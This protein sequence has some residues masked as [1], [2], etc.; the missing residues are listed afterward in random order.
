LIRLAAT[1]VSIR[2]ALPADLR[3]IGRLGALLVRTHHDF[4]PQRFIAAT[5]QTEHAYGS[6]LGTQL[7]EPNI[8][9]IV[10]DRSGEAI[11]Y[12]YA[13]IEG[14]DYMSLRGPAGVLY[15]IVFDPQLRRQGIGRMLLDATLAELK[16]RGA[17][18]VVLSTAE[19]NESAQRLFASA[20]FRRTMIEMTRELGPE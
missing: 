1:G 13:G 15:D 12:T 19:R 4:D 7:D 8:V 2:R 10:A 20:G 11:G 5:P 17:S 14:R 6:F 18:Q 3:A 9:V 16:A